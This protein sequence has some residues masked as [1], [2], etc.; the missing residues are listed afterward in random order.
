LPADIVIPPR[1]TVKPASF[2]AV[3]GLIKKPRK[4]TKALRA[5]LAGKPIDDEI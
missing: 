1:I 3:I 2:E 5:L 4:P